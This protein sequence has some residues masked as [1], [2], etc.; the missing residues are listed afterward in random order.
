MSSRAF[1]RG[2]GD[3]VAA[4]LPA[5]LA[6]P[7]QSAGTSLAQLWYGNRALHYECWLRLRQAVIEIGL[8]FEA[9]PLTNERLLG[10]FRSRERLMR[11]RLSGEV[12]LEEWDRGWARLWEPVALRALDDEL[13]DR[14]AA[15]LARYI[16]ALEPMLRD[17]LPVEVP[18]ELG[19]RAPDL[20]HRARKRDL[21][22]R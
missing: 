19:A 16:S 17:A 4:L 18:W 14:I 10:A 13:R 7:H 6:G 9:D 8:H 12:R 1:V 21:R 20:S 5:D 11:R 3:A 2:V 15:R 22:A